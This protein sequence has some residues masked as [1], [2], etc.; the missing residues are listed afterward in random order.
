M[1]EYLS[2]IILTLMSISLV[3]SEE[4]E[5]KLKSGNKIT[6]EIIEIDEAGNYKVLTSVGEVFFNSNDI[7]PEKV[8]IITKDGDEILGVLTNEDNNTF[9]VKSNIGVLSINKNNVELIDFNPN[10]SKDD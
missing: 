10:T 4:R 6:G 3:L 9:Y 5:F 1:R 7:V 8:K 2:V